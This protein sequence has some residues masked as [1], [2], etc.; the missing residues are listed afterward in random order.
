MGA[1][2][3]AGRGAFLRIC[4]KKTPN[5]AG[6]RGPGRDTDRMTPRAAS[7]TVVLLSLIAVTGCGGGDDR[8]SASPATGQSAPTEPAPPDVTGDANPADVR[9]I[10]A[11]SDALREG[12][13]DAAAA[14]F[15]I[16]SVA[17]NGPLLRIR[18]ED[19]ARL[20]NASLPCGAILVRA[21]SEGDFTTA[22]FELT[23]RPGPGACGPGTGGRA[24]TA[25]V[26]ENGKITE[27][28]RVAIGGAEG[29]PSET[30]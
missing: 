17:E 22:T 24:E 15:A 29:A 1:G 13:V 21:E 5:A 30:V 7:T 9:V 14:Y 6:A 4:R 2:R 3:G 20:F 19:D 18:S 16:P 23:E 11:W 26:I 12:D 28:R 25:F 27:W 10:D 8:P